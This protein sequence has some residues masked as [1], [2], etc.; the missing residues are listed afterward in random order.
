MISGASVTTQYIKLLTGESSTP[1]STTPDTDQ[2]PEVEEPA[3][4]NEAVEDLPGTPTLN[5]QETVLEGTAGSSVD[6]GVSFSGDANDRVT[7]FIQP[8]DCTITL[9][10]GAV[11]A[12]GTSKKFSNTVTV[13]NNKLAGAKVNVGEQ[14]GLVSVTYDNQTQTITVAVVTE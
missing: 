2:T 6:L 14:Q 7:V 12:A 8:K 9:A 3:D 1:S 4:V 5:I 11:I 10:S 13:V